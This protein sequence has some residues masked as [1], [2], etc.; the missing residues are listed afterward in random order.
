MAGGQHQLVGGASLELC[1]GRK[2]EY[3][4]IPL[5]D[6]IKGWHL[7]WFIV[8]NHYKSLPPRSGR[9]PDVCTPSWVESPT[10]SEVTEAKVLLVEVCLLKDRG[11]TAEVVV[12]DF[13]F[14]NIQPLK[15]RAYPA[16]LYS[17]I[18]D[19][20]RVTNRR[21]PTEDLVS[22]LNMILRGRVSNVGAPV[23]YSTW[24]LPPY[25][26]FSEFVS[27][28]P[29][30]DGGLG[31]R[32]RPSP[33]DIEALI[34]PLRNLPNDEKQTHFEMPAS[35]DDAELDDVLSMLAGE[36]SDSTHA[37]LMAITA[38]QELGKTVETRKPEG[39]RPKRPRRVSRPS[40]PVEEK[41]K[42]KRRLRRLSC[43][44]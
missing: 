31:L 36:S 34:A 5:K 32:L 39:A 35:T 29:A 44:D 10:P 13:V 41:K 16:Y 28:S 22:R 37:E 43:L 40:A 26:S 18:N 3:L 27:N 8:E 38:G 6:S 9:Q 25:K 21:I 20:T 7:E 24:N 15:D 42:K 19:S 11:L 14:K 4:D 23:A 2:T 30:S 12:A 1:R 33:K 17:G